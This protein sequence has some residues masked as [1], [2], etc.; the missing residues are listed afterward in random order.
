MLGE[1]GQ[2]RGWRVGGLGWGLRGEGSGGE[3]LCPL[4]HGT[5]GDTCLAGQ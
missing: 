1:V 2:A 4:G 5:A 3:N